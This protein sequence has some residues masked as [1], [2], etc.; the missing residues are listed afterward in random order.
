MGKLPRV[1]PTLFQDVVSEL[2]RKT[3]KR[4]KAKKQRKK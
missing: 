4:R 2:K 3:E 1:P